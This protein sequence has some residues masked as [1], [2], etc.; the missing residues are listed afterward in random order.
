MDIVRRIVTS[1]LGGELTVSTSIGGGTTFTLEV[2]LTIAIIDVFS[3]ECASQAFVVPVASIEEIFE[4]SGLQAVEGPS[5]LHDL[6]I[7]LYERRG[8]PVPVIPL[9]RLLRLRRDVGEA[10]KALVIRRNGDPL[11]FAVDRMIGRLE[12][13]VR[14]IEDVL[15]RAPGIAGATDLGDGRPTLL[16]DLNELGATVATW[17]EVRPS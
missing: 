12:V 11:A 8:R 4:L 10:K 13:V 3:F 6:R 9:A 5:G 16:L 7:S 17:R 14:P 2:P 1:D 15:A